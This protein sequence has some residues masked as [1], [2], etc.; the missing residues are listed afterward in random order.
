MRINGYSGFYSA[1]VIYYYFYHNFLR[2]MSTHIAVGRK[3]PCLSKLVNSYYCADARR[4]RDGVVGNA[5][6]KK[7]KCGGAI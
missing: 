6:N 1:T 4:G 2:E 7:I 3:Y 5:N